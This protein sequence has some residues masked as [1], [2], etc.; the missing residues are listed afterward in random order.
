M[1]NSNSEQM[2]V[3][4]FS[5]KIQSEARVRGRESYNAKSRVFWRHFVAG[6]YRS[7]FSWFIVVGSEMYNS[8]YAVPDHSRSPVLVY[9]K[10]ACDFLSV[11]TSNV[12]PISS[13]FP[14]YRRLLIRFSL[15]AP[16]FNAVVCREPV[17]L[18]WRILASGNWRYRSTARCKAYFDTSDHLGTTRGW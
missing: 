17:N 4:Q 14:T 7:S 1:H 6:H 9:G 12:H 2:E 13:P 15:S 8:H 16:F 11:N 10:P 5:W 18:W 3:A